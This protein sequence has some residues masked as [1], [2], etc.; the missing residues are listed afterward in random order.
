QILAHASPYFEALLYHNFKESQKKEIVM[1]DVSV[2]IVTMLE[3]IYD[4]GKIDEKNLHQVLKMA[5][6]FDIPRIRKKEN[7]MM[8]DGE[9]LI[10]RHIQL[11]LSDHYKLHTLKTACWKLCPIKWMK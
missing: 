2:E 10:P 6:Q 5:D 4:T 7:W 8:G 3:L 9:F 1:N 11:F